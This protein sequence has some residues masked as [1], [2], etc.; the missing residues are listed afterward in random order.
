MKRI[1]GLLAAL[2][3]AASQPAIAAPV[4]YVT[5]P[6]G[7]YTEA[8]ND[9]IQNVNGVLPFAQPTASC[10]GTT[11]QTCNGVRIAVSVTGLTTAHGAL[12]AANTVTDSSVSASSQVFCQVMGYAGTGSPIAVNVVPGAGSF[13]MQIQNNDPSAA[14]NATVI[15]DCMVYN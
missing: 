10:T 14:L 6:T 1:L 15:T 2:L 8:V 4:P 12:A 11:A 5:A 7:T 13:V 3:F 9:A